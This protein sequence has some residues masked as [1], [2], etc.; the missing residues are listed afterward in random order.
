[1]SVCGFLCVT[2][3]LNVYLGLSLKIPLNFYSTSTRLLLNFC[4]T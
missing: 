4:L 1:M 2:W 3:L